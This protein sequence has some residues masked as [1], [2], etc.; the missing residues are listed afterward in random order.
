MERVGRSSSGLGR[1]PS[2]EVTQRAVESKRKSESQSQPGQLARASL[3]RK[4]QIK[5]PLAE[6]ALQR[7]VVDKSFWDA[8]PVKEEKRME[9]EPA[10][11][12]LPLSAIDVNRLKPRAAQVHSVWK[13]NNPAEWRAMQL[14]GELVPPQQNLLRKRPGAKRHQETAPAEAKKARRDDVNESVY[15][16]RQEL[17]NPGKSAAACLVPKQQLDEDGEPVCKPDPDRKKPRVRVMQ[18]E[19]QVCEGLRCPK[20]LWQ[21]LY[22]YQHRCVHWLWGLHRDKMGGIL[23]DEM[24]LG[25]T[26]QIIAYLAVLHHSGVLQNMRVQNTSL[27]AASPPRTGGV[28]IVCPATLISQWRNE[29]HLWYPPLRVCVMHQL[30]EEDRKESIQQASSHQGVLITSYETMR[31]AIDALLEATWVLVILDEGQKIRNPHASITIACKRFSTAHRILLSG[32]PIQNN[33]Q[34]LWSLFD[35]VCPGRLGTLPVFT[36]EFAQPIESGNLMGATEVKIAAAYQCALALRELTEP[37]ILRRTKAECM[38]VLNLPTKQEQ[39]LFCHLT[40]EQYHLY[41]QFLETEQAPERPK[42]PTSG[43]LVLAVSR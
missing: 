12:S 29:I 8:D 32:S 14:Q 37:C 43:C 2:G 13:E 41:V 11:S 21:A 27:G 7:K 30:N 15:Q 23:A 17:W 3:P 33:L 25:K 42:P 22:P 39:V 20:W 10:S 19:I 36:E 24:G 35:F 18:E 9:V 16:R 28:L 38:D 6:Q 31:I 1:A 26:V 40:A 5:L 4:G 34:E